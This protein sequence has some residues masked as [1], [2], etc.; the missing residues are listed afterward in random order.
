MRDEIARRLVH[1][2]GTAV[3]LAYLFA[4]GVEWVH[5]QALLVAGLAVALVLEV[6]RLVV[7]L[8]WW[9]YEKLTREY[10][11]DNLAGYFLAVFSMTVVALAF[12]P[13]VAVPAIL[14]LTIADPVSGLLGSGE[15]RTA[16]DV[17]VL[18]T[19]FAVATLLAVPFV[20]PVA[21]VLG[22][23]AATLADGVKPVIRGYVIDDNLTIPVAGAVAMFLAMQFLPSTPV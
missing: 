17:T 16:K 20:T 3:P 9:V 19:T 15:L 7:G 21:A 14:M 1:A 2:S 12:E 10:E 18:L 23:A 4:P 22:G 6:V 5:V 11:Q 8:D 13:A